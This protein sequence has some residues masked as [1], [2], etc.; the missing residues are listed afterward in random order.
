MKIKTKQSKSIQNGGANTEG[1][2]AN[3]GTNNGNNSD[4]IIYDSVDIKTISKLLPF[5]SIQFFSL[6]GPYALIAFSSQLLLIIGT[7]T[8]SFKMSELVYG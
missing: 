1:Q 3:V 6:L 5:P 4:G 2:C 8:F 7:S